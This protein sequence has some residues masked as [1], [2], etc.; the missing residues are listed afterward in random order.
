M[1]AFH[2]VLTV[3]VCA[4]GKNRGNGREASSRDLLMQDAMLTS[5]DL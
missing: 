4:Y 5:A 3:V 2:G 1:T